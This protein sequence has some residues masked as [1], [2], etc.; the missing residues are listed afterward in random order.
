MAADDGHV[1]PGVAFLVGMAQLV[2]D[3]ECFFAQAGQFDEDG[4]LPVASAADGFEQRNTVVVF[5]V[6]GQQVGRN[7][8]GGLQNLPGVAVVDFQ[9]GGAALGVRS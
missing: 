9:D 7:Q 1:A 5:V 2:G 6:R 4:G 8:V 3:G